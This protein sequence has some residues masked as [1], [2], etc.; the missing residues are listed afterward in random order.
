[1]TII[2]G[3]IFSQPIS[4]KFTS[5]IEDIIFF[6]ILGSLVFIYS[7]KDGSDLNLKDRISILA[8]KKDID[9]SAI[10]FLSDNIHPLL[11]YNKEA[12]I[13]ITIEDISDDGNFVKIYTDVQNN[14]VNMCSNDSFTIK[15]TNFT[16]QGV[17]KVGQD[18]GYISHA[19]IKNI[20]NSTGSKPI[21]FINK[22]GNRPLKSNR[23][24]KFP[25]KEF[26]VPKNGVAKSKMGWAVWE[27]LNTD[28]S[29]MDNWF[30]IGSPRFTNKI[31][32]DIRSII[33]VN[34]DLLFDLRIHID[35][36]NAKRIIFEG[37]KIE[38]EVIIAPINEKLFPKD[39]IQIIFYT[40]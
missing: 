8:T 23:T 13:D 15:D 2:N 27:K 29:I 18:Y 3:L 17:N 22:R 5:L 9:N 30:Y 6:G 35:K 31:H 20:E 40:K 37:Q 21:S 38:K 25:V 36:T 34:V 12:N 1:V 19:G 32:L 10:K 33:D 4:G 11:A 16:I 39:K 24:I 7:L 28:K 14:I 26:I